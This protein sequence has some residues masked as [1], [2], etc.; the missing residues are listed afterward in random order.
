MVSKA[1]EDLPEPLSPVITVRVLRGIS[2]E[3]FLRLCWRAPRTVILLIAME[4]GYLKFE[5][6][7]NS[8]APQKEH[9]YRPLRRGESAALLRILQPARLPSK[10][11]ATN[12]FRR[13]P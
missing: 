6:G 4:T 8:L 9:P 11:A 7:Q 1:R 13:R 10:R 3:T 2:T 5:T 12:D